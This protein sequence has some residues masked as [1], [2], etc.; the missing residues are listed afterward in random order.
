MKIVFNLPS[1]PSFLITEDPPDKVPLLYAMSTVINQVNYFSHS[2]F[3]DRHEAK[4][5]LQK[6]KE[7][8][9]KEQLFLPRYWYW[10]NPESDKFIWI[11]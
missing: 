7:Q 2:V 10:L 6:F 3:P 11:P 5:L 8:F 1:G 4:L 9:P